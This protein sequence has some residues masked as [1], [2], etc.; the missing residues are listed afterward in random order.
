M[1]TKTF[2]EGDKVRVKAT[3]KTGTVKQATMTSGGTRCL[4]NIDGRLHWF[5]AG[6]LEEVDETE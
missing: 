2:E 3:G 1:K 6:A 4:V 5:L